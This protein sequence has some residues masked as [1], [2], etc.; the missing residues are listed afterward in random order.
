MTAI[1]F[2]DEPRRILIV[3]PSAIGDVVHG[4]PILNLLHRRF[5][6]AQISWL[7][8]PACAGILDGH[9]FLHEVI[10]FDRRRFGQAWK[11]P[12][13]LGELYRFVSSLRERQFDLVIDLQGL[14]R[15]GWL[16][17]CT[18]APVRAGFAH[19][20][21][22]APLFYTHRIKTSQGDIHAIDRY[23]YLAEAVGCPREPVEF[24]FATS[25]ADRHSAAQLLADD[26]PY[27]LVLPGTNW[28]TKR[29]PI[30]YF[31]RLA[32]LLQ[33]EFGLNVVFAGSAAEVDLC[34]QGIELVKAAGSDGT[35][36][37]VDD[38]VV[39]NPPIN[40]AG[41]T[42]LRQ[43][44][45]LIER[46]SIIIAN[47]SGPMHIAA[48][49]DRPLVALFGPTNP[50][51]TGPYGHLDSVVQAQVPPHARYKRNGQNYMQSLTVD[52]VLAAVRQQLHG[53]K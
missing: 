1:T 9:P 24:I 21:E 14:F 36:T 51:R 40:L 49:L 15:S 43:L 39:A 13:A 53:K 26:R 19:A 23:L 5:A 44:T 20:R 18:R 46:A 3:K 32:V 4:L 35:S 6:Q 42:T 17:G 31:A 50:L 30:E 33:R 28:L 38:A 10:R 37:G 45:A 41:K 8:T 48:A 12:T 7:V 52:T 16:T 11:S 2:S 22:L 34:R 25:D 29:W 27:A 47:D